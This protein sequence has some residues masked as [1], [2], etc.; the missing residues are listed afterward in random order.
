MSPQEA[1]QKLVDRNWSIQAIAK[2]IGLHRSN[3]YR[4]YERYEKSIPRHE[5]CVK[6]IKLAN[7]GRK[8]PKEKK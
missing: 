6:L 7:S 2:E 1:I 8:P 4:A 3:V 5:T